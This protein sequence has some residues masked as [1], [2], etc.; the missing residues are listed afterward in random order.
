MPTS[1][2]KTEVA[3]V[4]MAESPVV[5][6]VRDLMSPSSD[7]VKDERPAGD[8]FTMTA[9]VMAFLVG[10]SIV[11]SPILRQNSWEAVLMHA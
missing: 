4:I 1:T 3:L 9:L 8:T 11:D 5:A 7:R 10:K 2:G 6:P